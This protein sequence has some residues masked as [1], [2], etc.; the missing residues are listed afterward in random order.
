MTAPEIV[1]VLSLN[2]NRSTVDPRPRSGPV[3]RLEEEIEE[4]LG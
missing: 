4:M 3:A 2:V 1:K